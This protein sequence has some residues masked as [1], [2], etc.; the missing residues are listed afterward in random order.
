M[1]MATKNECTGK[2]STF[3]YH[4]ENN[5]HQINFLYLINFLPDILEKSVKAVSCEKKSL[6][7]PIEKSILNVKCE[8]KIASVE[9][10]SPV[11]TVSTKI[12]S[13]LFGKKRNVERSSQVSLF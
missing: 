2:K 12:S 8:E 9:N 4:I 1:K 7:V 6:S 13:K 3:L 10:A 5:D 11:S